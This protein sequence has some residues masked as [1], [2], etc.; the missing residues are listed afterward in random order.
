[1]EQKQ[2]GFLPGRGN[3]M[4]TQVVF[5][6]KR[7]HCTAG[8]LTSAVSPDVRNSVAWLVAVEDCDHAFPG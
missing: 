3:T 5:P 1:M 2:E 8:E 6:G 7:I 4:V